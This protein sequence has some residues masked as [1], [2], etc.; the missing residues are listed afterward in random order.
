MHWKTY[1]RRPTRHRNV[2]LKPPPKFPIP[3]QFPKVN[4]DQTLGSF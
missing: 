4:M 2:L 3:I 1:N